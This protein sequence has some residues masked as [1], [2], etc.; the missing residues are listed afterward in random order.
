MADARLQ[1]LLGRGNYIIAELRSIQI[2]AWFW[3]LV[4][5]YVMIKIQLY[6]SGLDISTPNPL[7]F[8]I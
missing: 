2:K 5:S 3:Y 1:V 4:R 7:V 8:C 6:C